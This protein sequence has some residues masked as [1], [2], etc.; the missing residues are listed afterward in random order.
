MIE[1]PFGDGLPLVKLAV[2][3]SGQDG[4]TQLKFT[5]GAV[6]VLAGV[7]GTV[8]DALWPATS[9]TDRGLKEKSATVVIGKLF[10]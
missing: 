2:T 6:L 8:T 3:P 5:G 9:V 1:M 4:L 10:P 7:T